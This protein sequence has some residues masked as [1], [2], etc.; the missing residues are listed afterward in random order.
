[1]AEVEV[2]V[3]RSLLSSELNSRRKVEL[4]IR[5]ILQF[6]SGKR[7]LMKILL[8]ES[9]KGGV[10]EKVFMDMAGN[11]MKG[12]LNQ[13]DT[14]KHDDFKGNSSRFLVFEFFTGFMPIYFY[15]VFGSR[16]F[17]NYGLDEKKAEEYFIDSL[18]KSHLG[19]HEYEE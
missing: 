11:L 19:H 7:S 6:L 4:S 14:G 9:L 8:M 2:L 3:G 18:I 13:L 15:T 12:E 10:S 1:M 16:F 5:A 17:D